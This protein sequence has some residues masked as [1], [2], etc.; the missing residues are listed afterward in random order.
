MKRERPYDENQCAKLLDFDRSTRKTNAHELLD[1]DEPVYVIDRM[2]HVGHYV[3]DVPHDV[4]IDRLVIVLRNAA[5]VTE[6]RASFTRA[7][8]SLYIDT[9]SQKD[10]T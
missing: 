4:N 1:I 5:R 9:H 2:Q 3:I 10:T 6:L 8:R 7:G